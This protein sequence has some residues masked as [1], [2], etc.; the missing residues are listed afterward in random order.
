MLLQRCGGV[1]LPI[2]LD[3]LRAPHAFRRNCRLTFAD[4]TSMD[5][6][7]VS[8]HEITIRWMAIPPGLCTGYLAVASPSQICSPPATRAGTPGS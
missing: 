5:R 3:D 1:L 8:E 7:E 4:R 2:V 6:A